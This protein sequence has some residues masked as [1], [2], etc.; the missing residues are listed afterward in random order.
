MKSS[1]YIAPN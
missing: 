1:H